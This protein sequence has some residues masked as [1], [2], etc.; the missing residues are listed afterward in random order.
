MYVGGGGVHV[1]G[2]RYAV[3]F[4]VWMRMFVFVHVIACMTSPE[5]SSCVECVVTPGAQKKGERRPV[6]KCQDRSRCR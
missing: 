3:S 4:S 6:Q 1:C 2:H 5:G